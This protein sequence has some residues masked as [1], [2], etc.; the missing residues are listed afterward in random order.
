MSTSVIRHPGLNVNVT[1]PTESVPTW[2][3]SGWQLVSTAVAGTVFSTLDGDVG[4]LINA[5]GSTS[6]ALRGVTTTAARLSAVTLGVGA[7]AY[8]STLH[9]PIWSDGTVWRDAA[10]TAV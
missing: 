1:V 5:G 2:V 9:K 10:G 8:D 3:K 6:V 7:Q 4:G